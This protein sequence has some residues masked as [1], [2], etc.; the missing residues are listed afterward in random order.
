MPGFFPLSKTKSRF[1][2]VGIRARRDRC[3]SRDGGCSFLSELEAPEIH[4]S[5]AA[6]TEKDDDLRRVSMGPLKGVAGFFF[7]RPII[8]NG[9]VF[10]VSTREKPAHKPIA[11][12]SAVYSTCLRTGNTVRLTPQGVADFSPSISPS[13][14]RM[15]VAS[16]GVTREWEV[17]YK[18][19]LQTDL[20]VF[21]TE[22]G[23]GRKI[24]AGHGG[25]AELGGRKYNLLPQTGS[26]RVVEHIQTQTF[27]MQKYPIRPERITPPSV[28]GFHSLRFPHGELDSR[29]HS[30]SGDQVQAISRFSTC[31]R[32]RLFLSRPPSIQRFITTIPFLSADSLKLGFH[33]FRGEDAPNADTVVPFLERVESP[34]PTLALQRINGFFPAFSPDASLP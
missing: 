27:W 24:V 28:H 12:W 19:D 29:R 34:I 32:N 9:R 17:A 30:Q 2:D 6:K 31:S 20:Y 25:M 10:F 3:G 15:A 26:R 13:G 7:D 16:Y 33:R 22:D 14:K 11:S 18:E 1:Y 21:D 5:V 23:S 8:N 4:L